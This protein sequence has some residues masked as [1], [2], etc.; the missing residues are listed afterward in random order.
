M[1]YLDYSF[2]T[3]IS[4]CCNSLLLTML[5]FLNSLNY[6]FYEAK[7]FK[8]Q[9]VIIKHLKLHNNNILFSGIG[10][11]KMEQFGFFV[12]VISKKMRYFILLFI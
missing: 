6:T 12:V 9:L 11:N 4:Y 2:K 1:D 10:G 8:G 3:I 7:H 5:L